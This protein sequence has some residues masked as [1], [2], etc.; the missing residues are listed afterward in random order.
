MW[1]GRLKEGVGRQGEAEGD[2]LAGSPGGA[3]SISLRGGGGGVDLPFAHWSS[4]SQAPPPSTG[5]LL[6]HCTW[7]PYGAP[8]MSSNPLF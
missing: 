5:G 6:K 1:G 7:P 3:G 2:R 4:G 8:Q